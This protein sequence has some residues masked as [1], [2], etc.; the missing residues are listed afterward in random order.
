MTADPRPIDISNMPDLLRIIK[1]VEISKLMS[2]FFGGE[3]HEKTW[4]DGHTS[5]GKTSAYWPIPVDVVG[6]SYVISNR[7]SRPRPEQQ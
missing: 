7:E 1:E 3:L 4:L 2:R 5:K 6:F